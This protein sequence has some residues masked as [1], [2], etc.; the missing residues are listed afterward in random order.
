LEFLICLAVI[1]ITGLG[2]LRIFDL[3]AS[4]AFCLLSAISSGLAFSLTKGISAGLSTYLGVTID[5]A[6]GLAIGSIVGLIFGLFFPPLKNT[7]FIINTG[8]VIGMSIALPAGLIIN[9]DYSLGIGLSSTLMFYLCYFRILFYPFYLLSKIDFYSSP[10]HNDAAIFL[11]IYRSKHHLC[12]LAVNDPTTALKFVDFLLTYRPL[13]TKLADYIAYAAYAGSWKMFPLEFEILKEP[14]IYNESLKPTDSWLKQLEKLKEQLIS[15]RHQTQINLKRSE[16]E[17]FIIELDNFKQQTLVQ[18]QGWRDYYLQALA[19][20]QKAAIEELQ[21]LELQAQL[22]EPITAN[23]YVAGEALRPDKNSEVFLGRDDL[24]EQFARKVLSSVQMPMFLIQGQRRTGKTS[25]LNFLQQLL[26]SGFK[27]IYQD[28][29]D[30]RIRSIETWLADLRLRIIKGLD[31]SPVTEKNFA[32]WLDNWQDFQE[33][34]T[35][36]SEKQSYKLILAFDE[37]EELHNLLHEQPQLGG[38]LLAA[39]RSFSQQQN[40]VVFLFVG[41]ALFSELQQPNWS[42]YFVQ[43][44]RFRVDYLK[45]DDAI[46]L[47]TKPVKLVYPPEIP[48]QM[49]Q[50]TQGHPALLQLLCEKM[51]NIANRDMKKNMNQADLDEVVSEVINDRETAPMSVFWGQF[52]K[53]AACKT[54]VKQIMQGETPSDKMQF[55]RLEEHQFII[56]QNEQW[57]LR[58]PLFE[59][60]LMK[61]SDRI[62]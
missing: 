54:T 47:I 20:W 33:W 52:C 6:R 59:R 36:I 26:G 24:K 43:A 9:W 29:Q 12:A 8:L 45:H 10:Y 57:R 42:E 38:R 5:L 61:F 2:M 62:S 27:V 31:L 18:H 51:V 40:K 25:L 39:M 30:V 44:Q 19:V 28:L 4:L 15:Y 21:Q 46:Q 22:Q 13:Q 7:K 3:S 37:Y 60:W 11:P 17:K 53:D 34:L 41:A 56:E 55:Y 23:V 14:A 16:F 50:L 48:E 58:V 32:D 49:F 35:E 1:F